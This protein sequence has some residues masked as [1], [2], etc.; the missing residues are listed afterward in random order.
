MVTEKQQWKRGT[1]HTSSEGGWDL[2]SEQSLQLAPQ[3]V[4]LWATRINAEFQFPP[5]PSEST[6][7]C[8][9]YM[10]GLL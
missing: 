4:C 1:K 7:I 9:H 8:P 10:A 5:L 3:F 2:E 6:N